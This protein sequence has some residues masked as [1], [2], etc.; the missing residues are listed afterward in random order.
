MQSEHKRQ[1]PCDFEKDCPGTMIRTARGYAGVAE[2]GDGESLA[3]P[4]VWYEWVCDHDT[5][6]SRRVR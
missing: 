5:S 3:T 2:V 1:I 4:V 6:H